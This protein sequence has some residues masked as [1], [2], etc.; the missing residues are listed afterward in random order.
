MFHIKTYNQI[1]AAGLAAFSDHYDISA[2]STTPD[3]LLLRSHRLN[4]E[5]VPD[6]VLVIGRAGAGTNNIPVAEMTARGIP[7]LNA[8]G[9]NANA[10]KELV[11]TGML[12]AARHIC[13]AWD[14]AR[15]ITGDD[16]ALNTQVEQHKK[17]FAGTELAG[18]TLGVIGLG[19]I[20]VKVANMARQLG[21]HVIGYDPHITVENAWEL[22]ASVVQAT[23]VEAALTQADFITLH[24]PSLPETHH[25]INAQRLALCRPGAILINMARAQIVDHEAVATALSAGTLGHYVSDFPVESLIGHPK[26]IALPHLGASTQ[27]AEAQCAVMAAEQIQAYLEH[28]HI[29]HA[30]NFP[31]VRMEKT[32]GKRVGIM[33]YNQPNMMAKITQA[34]GEQ[35]LNIVDM[36]NQSRGEAAY[37][38]L[39]YE[40]TTEINVAPFK[41]I[42][43]VIRL[44]TLD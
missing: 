44:R 8:P 12:L 22:R 21:M 10:V 14:Y 30:V 40:G 23:T 34:I 6:S 4:A 43:G 15:G 38:L 42:D 31:N 37:T 11:L 33:H 29:R 5:E 3:G 17:H 2:T 13:P 35:S 7:V 19:K 16:A 20:G 32:T 18:K 9:A 28:G 39:D 1:A 41:A 24:V 26:V 36:I 25:L 27:E